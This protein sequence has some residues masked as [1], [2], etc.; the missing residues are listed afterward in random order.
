MVL[1]KVKKRKNPMSG[2]MLYKIPTIYVNIHPRLHWIVN[3]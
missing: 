2:Y 1:A 3:K